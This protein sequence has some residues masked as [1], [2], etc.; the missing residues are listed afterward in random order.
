MSTSR[1]AD[2][3]RRYVTADPAGPEGAA[4]SRPVK[5]NSY[6]KIG[7]T[8]RKPSFLSCAVVVGSR[9]MWRSLIFRGLR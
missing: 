1:K 9:G 4:E 2:H 3:G 8:D 6:T 5:D 7:A